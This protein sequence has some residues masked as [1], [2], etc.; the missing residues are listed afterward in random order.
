MKKLRRMLSF[1]LLAAL[2]L[3]LA[4]CSKESNPLVGRWN[5]VGAEIAANRTDGLKFDDLGLAMNVSFK[6]NGMFEMTFSEWDVSTHTEG[7]YTAEGSKITMTDTD[8]RI[9]ELEYK[10]SNDNNMTLYDF[11]DYGDLYLTRQ[12]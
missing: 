10:I 4:A 11:P 6:R 5:M 12:K 2:V 9:T 1:I 3:T 8:G 7:T